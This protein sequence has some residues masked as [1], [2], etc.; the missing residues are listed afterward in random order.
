MSKLPGL[1]DTALQLLDG[2]LG[3][4]FVGKRQ[5]ILQNHKV[6]L[7]EETFC[8]LRD[9]IAQIPA[10][11]TRDIVVAHA[12][13]LD[14][15][16]SQGIFI[17]FDELAL[18]FPE[19]G[20]PLPPVAASTHQLVIQLLDC[21]FEGQM[22][23]ICTHQ[24]ALVDA[25]IV[26]TLR[27]SA[28]EINDEKGR[29]TFEF[30]ADRLDQCLTKGI[31]VV[32]A[33]AATEVAFYRYLNRFADLKAGGVPIEPKFFS[34]LGE[35][36]AAAGE[37]E[38]LARR[39]LLNEIHE[40]DRNVEDD[41]LMAFSASNY[42]WLAQFA[43]DNGEND[44]QRLFIGAQVETLM[45]L[46]TS[47]ESEQPLFEALE[48]QDN[49]IRSRTHSQ[50]RSKNLEDRVRRNVIF[51][52][53][54]SMRGDRAA[55]GAALAT[56]LEHG[57]IARE[58]DFTDIW[59]ENQ[60]LL[61]ECQTSLAS[62]NGEADQWFQAAEAFQE[63]AKS[64][65]WDSQADL[66][67]ITMIRRQKALSHHSEQTGD[68]AH[69]AQIIEE[70]R[71][72]IDALGPEGAIALRAELTGAL[73]AATCRLGAMTDQMSLL[74]QSIELF[75]DAERLLVG[76]PEH[77]LADI[78]GD[79]GMALAQFGTMRAMPN[80]LERA[81]KDMKRAL[82][83]TPTARR[84]SRTII[85]HNIANTLNELG[86][87][88]GE[89]KHLIEAL[90]ILREVVAERI[91]LS[92]DADVIVTRVS[93]AA[94]LHSIGEH[95]GSTNSVI[96][97]IEIMNDLLRQLSGQTTPRMFAKVMQNRGVAQRTLARLD[98]HQSEAHLDAAAESF[99]QAR[100]AGPPHSSAGAD[101]GFVLLQL[102]RWQEAGDVLTEVLAS[103][104]AAAFAAP[105]TGEQNRVIS[106]L[107]GIGDAIAVARLRSGEYEAAIA[108]VSKG[109]GLGIALSL[110]LRR[111][112]RGGAR[113]TSLRS[114]WTAA[115]RRL[116]RVEKQILE[117]STGSHVADVSE[118]RSK[119]DSITSD[120][121]DQQ[122]QIVAMIEQEGLA[123]AP[124]LNVMQIGEALSPRDILVVP[125]VSPAGGAVLVVEPGC[126]AIS[127]RHIRFLD[128]LTTERVSEILFGGSASGTAPGWF[129]TYE[130]LR[131]LASDGQVGVD[132]L[133][134]WNA[135]V[136]HVLDALATDLM[137][138]LDE[139]LRNF[140]AHPEM[141][142]AIM[143]PGR[144]GVLPLQNAGRRDRNGIWH[145]FV[146]S[147]AVRL[148]PNLGAIGS[149]TNTGRKQTSL[150]AVTDPLGDLGITENPAIRFFEQGSVSELRGS[151]A[152]PS[153]V[154]DEITGASHLS[155][156]CHGIFNPG[157]PLESGLLLANEE[158]TEPKILTVDRLRQLDLSFVRL[159]IL[160]ACET[161]LIDVG[162]FP[163]EF[164]GLP[165]AFIEAGAD[166]VLASNWLVEKHATR[167]LIQR[168]VDLHLAGTSTAQAIRLATIEM[169]DLSH[170]GQALQFGSERAKNVG[171]VPSGP[172]LPPS[173][174]F[175]WAAFSLWG[176]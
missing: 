105:T 40:I 107:N 74:R 59:I 155:F 6:L 19:L 67:V 52:R 97:S 64:L 42:G 1:S 116:E 20:E 117:S 83:L 29:A 145:C 138:P 11:D 25:V 73:A 150:L 63:L 65:D 79:R 26:K 162:S 62:L 127:E 61:A 134:R 109:R 66:L 172:E 85:N 115:S 168:F 60:R 16:R 44:E 108:A 133:A 131:D 54:A 90:K 136:E 176:R 174:P 71:D 91:A 123:A 3:A 170:I 24:A 31:E 161:G 58:S 148:L 89:E 53:L 110:A 94:T 88:P 101:L 167:Q 10:G 36:L 15:C 70:L 124:A 4:D 12:H 173:A 32:S 135:C 121:R 99:R 95:H 113:F 104:T 149:V 175:F 35:F 164:V 151:D 146:D 51:G 111:A 100:D 165:A 152:T 22:E 49:L 72:A 157:D 75:D 48:I 21:P 93:L 47:N 39:L 130:Q 160:G 50:D 28:A 80:F 96:E 142:L 43:G 56:C 14:N 38:Y 33:A 82:A 139:H 92:A 27:R 87:Y 2:L 8:F 166:S 76:L 98:P 118:L 5:I 45:G 57:K 141:E 34:E 171:V 13:L 102:R 128:D 37:S 158:G 106:G 120:L 30:I 119:R 122:N 7:T 153:A 126:R 132:A 129:S 147:W 103:G 163:D 159:A 114:A 18:Q 78:L 23:F 17:T 81:L 154:L 169:R 41:G 156:Y 9:Y 125:I 84:S 55:L 69:Q 68:S 137:N 143:A 77:R 86:K 144:L 140:G 46:A 112:G